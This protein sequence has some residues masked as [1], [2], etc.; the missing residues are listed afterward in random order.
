MF[1][2]VVLEVFLGLAF[3]FLTLSLVVTTAQEM[4]AGLLGMRSANLIEGV[5]NLLNDPDGKTTGL[6]KRIFEHPLVKG[7]YKGR[8]GSSMGIFGRGPSY[9]PSNVFTAAL[10]DTLRKDAADGKAAPISLDELFGHGPEIVSKIADGPLK[11]VLTLMVG[12]ALESE[13]S[14]QR[15]AAIVEEKLSKWFDDAMQRTSGWYKRRAQV[16]GLV[17]ASVL[18]LAV[19]ADA[20]SYIHQLR[21]DANL[22]GAVVEAA[23]V[24]ADQEPSAA[25][26]KTR[27]ELLVQ[28][29]VFALGWEEGE[30][31]ASRFENLPVALRSIA[32]W[33]ITVLAVSLGAAFWF[34]VTKKALSLRASGPKPAS[35]GQGAG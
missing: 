3:L 21:T 20:L 19:D 23:S 29:E 27:E 7:L 8:A 10:L 22:R 25:L 2:S 5:R 6:S 33:L 11:E 24:V 31:F 18:V 16:I 13:R 15:R 26:E 30:T 17:L 35:G 14:L 9:V 34:D 28:V 4:L 1:G 32:G 12:P